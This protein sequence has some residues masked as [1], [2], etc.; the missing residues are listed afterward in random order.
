MVCVHLIIYMLY[1]YTT[2]GLASTSVFGCL[3]LSVILV[4]FVHDSWVNRLVFIL[5][6][7]SNYTEELIRY[8]GTCGIS[9]FIRIRSDRYCPDGQNEHLHPRSIL[10]APSRGLPS[11]KAPPPSYV[12]WERSRRCSLAYMLSRLDAGAISSSSLATSP[13]NAA[14]ASMCRP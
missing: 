2:T 12:S 9:L 3:W 6:E 14:P 1:Y 7:N 4:I 10:V 13:R 5:R 8:W 11:L